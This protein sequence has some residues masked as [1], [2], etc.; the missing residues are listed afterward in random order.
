MRRGP[1]WSTCMNPVMASNRRIS[2][3]ESVSTGPV[4]FGYSTS[5]AA[6]G[7][8]ERRED[9][10]DRRAKR[11]FLTEQGRQAILDIRQVLTQVEQEMLADV[12]NAEIAALSGAFD[13]ISVRVQSI[14]D[15]QQDHA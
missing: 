1:R 2:L 8:I 7:L 10:H 13:K 14:L 3:F 12:S 5:S 4:S 15:A 11:V 9:D 6:R